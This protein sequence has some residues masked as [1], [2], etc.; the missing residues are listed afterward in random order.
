M[1]KLH[2]PMIINLLKNQNGNV[3]R[4]DPEVLKIVVHESVPQS[5]RD[6][7]II[8]APLRREQRQRRLALHNTQA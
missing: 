4:D 6:N 1:D 7:F 5:M 8:M 2:I 3:D